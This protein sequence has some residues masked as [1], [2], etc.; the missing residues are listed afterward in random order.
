MTIEIRAGFIPLLDCAPLIVARQMGFAAQEGIDLIVHRETSWAALRDRLAVAHLDVAHILAPMPIAANLGLGPLQMS[1]VVPIA[2]GFGGNTVTVSQ[3][4]WRELHAAGAAVD[5]DAGAAVRALACVVA[6]RRASGRKR[7]VLGIVHAYSAHHYQLAYWMASG[8]VFPGRDV[9][10]V[11]VPPSLMPAALAGRQ[12]DGFCA[13]EPWGSV[14]VRQGAGRILTTNASIWRSCPEKVL[15]VREDW[16]RERGEHAHRLVRAVHRAA[17]WCDEGE[18]REALGEI[19]ARAGYIGLPID[20]LQPSLSGNL[21]A[22]DGN[23]RHVDGLL[24]VARNG[25]TFPW[26][27][28]A[29]WLYTQMVRWCQATHAREALDLVRTTYAPDVFRAALAP[30]G[31]AAPVHDDRL[32]DGFFDA[33]CFDAND[34]EAYLASFAP[35]RVG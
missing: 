35:E 10:L 26:T 19:L 9:E 12:I 21:I 32:E 25:A 8:G 13:G 34:V 23:V 6:D 31:V 22:P 5:F 4:V 15:G 1:L 14:A 16:A 2:L 17:V 27:S 28:Q 30:L 11:V 18:N 3:D 33:R 24:T 20:A 7:L 29:L